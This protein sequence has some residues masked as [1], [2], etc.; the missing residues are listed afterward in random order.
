MYILQSVIINKHKMNLDNAI[1]WMIKHDYKIHKM[2]ETVNE[3]RFRQEDPKKIK[4][5]GYRIYRTVLIDP[6]KDIQLII[7]YKEQQSPQYN[8]L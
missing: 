5:L 6:K 2:D 1:R 3:Y 8:Y 4:K 7:A